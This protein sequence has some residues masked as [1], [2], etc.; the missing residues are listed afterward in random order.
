M[1]RRLFALCALAALFT[2]PALASDERAVDAY[3]RGDLATARSEWLALLDD[4]ARAPVGSDRARVL[5]DLGNVAFREGKT[6]EA[7]GWYTASLRLRPRDADTWANLEEARS[8]AKLEPADR[9]DLTSTL[10]RGVRSF[11][12]AEA[13]WC[14]L[15][16][17]LVL[18]AA[19]A[20]E[21]LR[22]GR[23]ARWL[24]V[25][26]A[27]VACVGF[28]PCV[29]HGL[30]SGERTLLVIQPDGAA[31]RS[32]PRDKAAN[33]ADLPAG[34]TVEHVDDLPEW[35]KVKVG[36]GLVGWVPKSMV[37]ALER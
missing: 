26:A 10:A 32:E 13:R 3:R 27:L 25:G 19:L 33:T 8:R 17:L 23:L 18:G 4:S 2:L 30:Q 11:T 14:A 37:F 9:G 35:T 36:G 34:S 7:V 24:A 28:A 16:G 5:Y 12:P 21:A 20:Y 31:L 6:L 1:I 15:G 22:G 29:A